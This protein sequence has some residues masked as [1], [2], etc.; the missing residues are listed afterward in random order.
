MANERLGLGFSLFAIA[1]YDLVRGGGILPTI[2]GES[3]D[4]VAL[5]ERERRLGVVSLE[6]GQNLLP[7]VA[8][9]AFEWHMRGK[10]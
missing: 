10:E 5:M 4:L 7:G 6:F 8:L 1:D 2:E 3:N 9:V